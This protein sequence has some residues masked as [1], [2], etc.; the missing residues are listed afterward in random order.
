MNAAELVSLVL[1]IASCPRKRQQIALLKQPDRLCY[2][3]HCTY[4]NY[5]HCR[6]LRLEGARNP[7]QWGACM[8][9]MAASQGKAPLWP[10]EQSPALWAECWLLQSRARLPAT[11]TLVCHRAI[12][13][14]S[15]CP[16]QAVAVLIMPC[17]RAYSKIPPASTTGFACT[18]GRHCIKHR[19]HVCL[20]CVESHENR[21][22]AQTV[23]LGSF[24]QNR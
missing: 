24:W 5:W 18:T 10:C 17:C 20:C 7:E 15:Q 3:Q 13:G 1:G 22:Q 12:L 8:P 23:S 14:A 11:R 6:L 9:A 21:R 4:T 2:R 19:P 16:S